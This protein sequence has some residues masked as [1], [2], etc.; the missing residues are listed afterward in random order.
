[1]IKSHHSG[2][3]CNYKSIKFWKKKKTR[4]FLEGCDNG[5]SQKLTFTPSPAIRQQQ[6]MFLNYQRKS[7][8]A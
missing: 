1:M 2:G 4:L 7:K 3:L 5:G 8:S 6:M